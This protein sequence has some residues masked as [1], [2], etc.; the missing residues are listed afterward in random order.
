MK[1]YYITPDGKTVEYRTAF[2]RNYEDIEVTHYGQ[3]DSF[4]QW[5]DVEKVKKTRYFRAGFY[6]VNSDVRYDMP[7]GR[8]TLYSVIETPTG[9]KKCLLVWHEVENATEEMVEKDAQIQRDA[10]VVTTAITALIGIAIGIWFGR[11]YPLLGQAA[12][13]TAGAA[14]I[15]GAGHCIASPT[16]RLVDEQWLTEESR[17]KLLAKMDEIGDERAERL[18]IH[19]RTYALGKV[20]NIEHA[21]SAGDPHM[22][23]FIMKEA[24]KDTIKAAKDG[25]YASQGSLAYGLPKDVKKYPE[26]KDNLT[27]MA[28]IKRLLG[29]RQKTQTSQTVK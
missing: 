22:T 5:T 6:Y 4:V 2:A 10:Q 23:D 16:D 28:S 19:N 14:V 3:K 15:G 26:N 13:A 27:V 25:N 24:T 8:N 20:L 17:A 9:D 1:V 21:N 18:K 29:W 7:T 12:C 11:D